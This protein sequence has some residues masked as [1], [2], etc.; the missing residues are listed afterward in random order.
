MARVLAIYVER[1]SDVSQAAMGGRETHTKK[2]HIRLRD[3]FGFPL[4]MNTSKGSFETQ[5]RSWNSAWHHIVLTRRLDMGA[6]SPVTLFDMHAD[7]LQI[8]F[9]MSAPR[10]LGFSFFF[11]FNNEIFCTQ[12]NFDQARQREP[13]KH[14]D[15]ESLSMIF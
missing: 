9:L 15:K 3:L 11:F 13:H 2:L 1:C 8:R 7:M 6:V 4:E 10:H 12:K 14:H 5:E